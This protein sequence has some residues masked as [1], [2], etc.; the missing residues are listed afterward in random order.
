[1]A[2]DIAKLLEEGKLD[3]AWAAVTGPAP[4]VK[5]PKYADK[6][7]DRI[8]IGGVPEPAAARAERKAAEKLAA[9]EQQKLAAKLELDPDSSQGTISYSEGNSPEELAF[10]AQ[11]AAL[12]PL[13]RIEREHDFVFGTP[14]EHDNAG[15]RT[16]ATVRCVNPDCSNNDHV[17]L[18][19]DTPT[20]V[21]C[22]TCGTLLLCDHEPVETSITT[23]TIGA[24][25]KRTTQSCV[26]CST[27]ISTN[28][29][30]LPPVDL[31][32]L[33][34]EIID[35]PLGGDAPGSPA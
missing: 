33:P 2:D 10:A 14:D 29:E 34:A 27:V 16:T 23:G 3:E 31:N 19:A 13:E 21:Y 22:G 24:P 5:F 15:A 18:N 11:Q 12:T 6:D 20:P 28:D 25:I 9:A 17:Q 8:V 32:T 4:E 35:T 1:M 30:P 26:K 7:D